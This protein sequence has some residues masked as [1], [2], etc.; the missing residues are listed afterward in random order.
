M[1]RRQMLAAAGGTGLLA[2]TAVPAK[3]ATTR[4][5]RAAGLAG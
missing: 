1:S 4:R 2:A 5:A 3:A